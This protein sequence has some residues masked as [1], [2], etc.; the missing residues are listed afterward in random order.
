LRT[1]GTD[2]TVILDGFTISGAENNH[3]EE[4]IKRGE[5]LA[6]HDASLTVNNCTF[7]DNG[8]RTGP[9]MYAAHGEPTVA[10]SAFVD[11]TT[12]T[13][14]YALYSEWND[15]TVSDCRFIGNRAGGMR[16][17]GSKPIVG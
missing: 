11:N 15:P 4:D 1:V 12:Y 17:A 10:N 5:G 9:A 13:N 7:I 2:S 16:I 8:G 14:S 6:A 3:H